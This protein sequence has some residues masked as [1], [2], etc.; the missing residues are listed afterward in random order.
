VNNGLYLVHSFQIIE[1]AHKE[2]RKVFN[3]ILDF[4]IEPGVKENIFKNIDRTSD[5]KAIESDNATLGRKLRFRTNTPAAKDGGGLLS[6]P[7][8]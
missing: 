1:S 6:P 2:G 3:T 7:S 8:R 5:P 4:A